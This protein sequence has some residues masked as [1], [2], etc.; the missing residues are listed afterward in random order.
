MS[1]SSR[2][3]N[4][5]IIAF[6]SAIALVGMF[7]IN[8]SNNATTIAV[9]DTS[10]QASHKIYLVDQETT[11]RIS[12]I[13]VYIDPVLE[14]IESGTIVIEYDKDKVQLNDIYMANGFTG[15]N[16]KID[17]ALG[18]ATIEFEAVVE[19]SDENEF[20]LAEVHILR[21]SDEPFVIKLSEESLLNTSNSKL[22]LNSLEVK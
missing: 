10:A 1:D 9:S 6:F 13:G 20:K 21:R 2:F 17:P 3:S 22:V 14:S 16:Q 12:K 11:E 5:L 8:L 18:K 7:L 19:T 4:I 15:L